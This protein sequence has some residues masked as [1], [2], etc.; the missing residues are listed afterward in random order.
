MSPSDYA[1]DDGRTG[2]VVVVDCGT[3]L[4]PDLRMVPVTD[5]DLAWGLAGWLGCAALS[6]ALCALVDRVS[7]PE[8]PL[9]PRRAS[10]PPGVPWRAP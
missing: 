4:P 5:I 2:V 7:P 6:V 1:S 3:G 10:T 8:P 9:P